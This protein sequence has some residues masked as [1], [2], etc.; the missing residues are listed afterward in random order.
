[1]IDPFANLFRLC[2]MSHSEFTDTESLSTHS[3]EIYFNL[4]NNNIVVDKCVDNKVK[5]D[6]STNVCVQKVMSCMKCTII[7]HVLVQ[8]TSCCYIMISS[9]Y[10]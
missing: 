2:T 6:N 4:K 8:C 1:M 5:L 3:F 7:K 9:I 10:T